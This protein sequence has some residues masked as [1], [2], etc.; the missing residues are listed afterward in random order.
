MENLLAFQYWY[1]ELCVKNRWGRGRKHCFVSFCFICGAIIVDGWRAVGWGRRSYLGTAEVESFS[2]QDFSQSNKHDTFWHVL[3]TGHFYVLFLWTIT[4][5]DFCL[6]EIYE[7]LGFLL[8]A[9]SFKVS[10]TQI[11]ISMNIFICFKYYKI[12]NQFFY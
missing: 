12:W 11:T 6:L 9:I 8:S 7:N 5:L 2:S 4:V 3:T 1:C 10:N